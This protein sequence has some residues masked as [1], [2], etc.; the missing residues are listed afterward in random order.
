MDSKVVIYVLGNLLTAV[1]IT[2]FLPLGV[3]L[4]YGE[5]CWFTFGMTILIAFGIGKGFRLYGT[6]IQR[7]L[8]VR[9]GI[10]ITTLGWVA[11]ALIGMLPY[12][13]GHYLGVIEGWTESIS[14]FS[15]TGATVISDVSLIPQS[16]LLWRSET[17]WLGGLGIIVIFI[18]FLPQ[19]GHGTV[20]MFNAESTGPSSSRSLPRIR[21]M[22]QALFIVYA[23][24]T[25]AVFLALWVSGLSPVI[26][27]NHAFSTIATGGFSPYNDSVAHFH[28][29]YIEGILIV[30]MLLSSANFGMYVAMWKR[31]WRVAWENTE[32]RCYLALVAIATLT[33]AGN[34]MIVMDVPGITAVRQALFQVVS[35]SSSTGY[36]STDFDQWPSFS[37][38]VLLLLMFIGGCAG[39]TAGGFKVTRVMLL[40][41]LLLNTIRQKIHP[42]AVMTVYSNHEEVSADI[43]HGVARFFFVCVMINVVC[44]FLLVW[45]GVPLFAAMSVS[46]SC[47]SNCGP[48]FGMFGATCTY[49]PLPAFSKV[50]VS[51]VMLMGR[52]ESFTVLALFMPSFWKSYKNW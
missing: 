50:I 28:N 42:G 46:V 15:G 29:P 12:I 10:A 35:L 44:V 23:I 11:V 32:Y 21:E 31:G 34:I 4:W 2:L 38:L 39:S 3:A 22:A 18:A 37:K 20:H 1:A 49:A 5:S 47:L 27:L 52:L 41:H 7:S 30:F 24:F 51:I 19:L 45:D 14:G 25:G 26:A 8:S 33:I 36:V 40:G 48:G 13:L 16:V 9:E 43:V 6:V 17:H